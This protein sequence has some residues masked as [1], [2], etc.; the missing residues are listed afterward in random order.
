MKLISGTQTHMPGQRKPKKRATGQ[1]ANG[2]MYG[3]R[4]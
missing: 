1:R 2:G 3:N 4:H